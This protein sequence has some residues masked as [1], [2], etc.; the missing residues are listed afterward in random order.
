LVTYDF[1]SRTAIA[2]TAATFAAKNWA[3]Y[4]LNAVGTDVRQITSSAFAEAIRGGDKAIEELVRSRV[5]I[6]GIV[7]SNM[8]DFLNPQMIVLGGGL[9]DSLSRIVRHEVIAGI[10]AHSSPAARRGLKVVTTKHQHNA[11]TIG[12]AQFAVDIAKESAAKDEKS[13]RDLSRRRAA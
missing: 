2:G 1:A 8:V 4:L 5:R 10:H 6:V 7:L 9:T 12:A 13:A 3:P 11:V